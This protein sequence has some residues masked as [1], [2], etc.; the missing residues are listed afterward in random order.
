MTQL[1]EEI[2]YK[3]NII[4]INEERLNPCRSPACYLISSISMYEE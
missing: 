3:E 4:D 1:N 2:S